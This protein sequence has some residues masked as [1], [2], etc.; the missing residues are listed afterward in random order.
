MKA[1]ISRTKRVTAVIAVFALAALLVPI[2]AKAK[3][4][5]TIKSVTI[6]NKAAVKSLVIGKTAKLKVNVKFDG[7]KKD[8]NKLE[9]KS[10]RPSVVSVNKKGVITAIAKGS[11]DIKVTSKIDSK[12]SDTVK[13]SVTEPSSIKIQF[14]EPSLDFLIYEED[15]ADTEEPVTIE[16]WD[17]DENEKAY[18]VYTDPSIPVT[19]LTFTS[20][21]EKIA[22]V[23]EHGMITVKGF[24]EVTI[25]AA[26]KKNAE[27]KA[28]V[29]ITIRKDVE[30]DATPEDGEEDSDAN[31][32]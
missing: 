23:D 10:S 14:A 1:I 26:Y 15:I 3:G 17:E 32:I 8:A 29:K 2:P 11:A 24:G 7:N 31:E 25:T 19:M 5:T 4:D 16:L 30:T 22:T 12:K 13:V 27:N 28:E 9:F 6:S 21:D 18:E 20:S